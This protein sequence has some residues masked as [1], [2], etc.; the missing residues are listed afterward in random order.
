[1]KAMD[2]AYDSPA[3]SV[4]PK[5]APGVAFRILVADDEAIARDLMSRALQRLGH[6][7]TTVADGLEAWMRFRQTPFPVVVTDIRM[8]GLSGI[9]LLKRI[10][11]ENPETEV[12]LV[13]GFGDT[14]LL[15]EALRHGASNFIEKPFDESEFLWHV[16]PAFQRRALALEAELMQLEFVKLRQKEEREIRML[17]LGQLLSGL[18]YE[19]HSPFAFIKGNV[20]LLAAFFREL[21][22]QSPEGKGLDR[23][24]ITEMQKLL[25][26]IQHGIER[27]ETT[28]DAVRTFG[29][30]PLAPCR[31]VSLAG[32]MV[33]A[34][35][36]ALGKKPA[37]AR[38][39][40]TPPPDSFV[41]EANT[42]EL[43]RCFVNLL[44][45]AFDAVATEGGAVRF[46]TREI[47][48]DTP[49]FF[50]FVEVVVEDE[51]PGMPQ[52]IIDEVF[53]PFFTTRD[54]GTGLGLTIAY[55][56][57]KRNGAQMEIE[58]EEGKG[59]VVTLRVPFQL[60][61]Q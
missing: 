35:N 33:R 50:G 18:A 8:P 53:T 21:S 60:R 34:F 15:I 47:P 20:E 49:N 51:G 5:Q 25:L 59:T 43:E 39:E 54:G 28:L 27:I 2:N 30:R 1:M 13:S 31:C 17:A 16:E 55:E 12:V 57:A 45:N 46:Y 40:I 58:S 52:G 41:V 56:A 19:I 42:E 24:E 32:V 4:F 37:G 44:L 11:K 36:E 48:Y 10:R 29:V 9:E 38:A 61:G 22:K 6:E 3:G 26:D 7:V 23:E 14:A